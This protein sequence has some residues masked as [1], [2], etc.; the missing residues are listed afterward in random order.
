MKRTR[1][2][3]MIALLL[4]TV[5][6]VSLMVLPVCAAD[7][8]VT[9]VLTEAK[10]GVVQIYGLGYDRYNRLEA[11]WVGSGFCVS[12][13]ED[14]NAVFVTN[15]HVATGDGNY[16]EDHV[17]LWIL[18]ENCSIRDLDYQPDPSRSIECKIITTTFGSPDFAIIE[19]TKPT[20]DYKA[21]P[22]LSSKEVEI[23]DTVYALGYPANVGAVN[24]S[25][26][27]I[28]DITVTNGIVS[29]RMQD[30]FDATWVLMHT[31]LISGGN[32]GGPL[33]TEQGAVVGVNTYTFADN[34]YFAIY[35]D[36]IMDALD[37]EGIPYQVY[38]ETP[39]NPVLKIMI[40]AAI[41]L[42][43]LAG[44]VI[45]VVII[46]KGKKPAAD[47]VPEDSRH[48][49]PV[50]AP[51][52]RLKM[53][54]GR[55]ILVN[56]PVMTIGRDPGCDICVAREND[57]ISRY[58]CKLEIIQ[59]RLVVSDTASRNGTFI[60]GK[61]IPAGTRVALKIGSSF[62]MGKNDYVITVI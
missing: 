48:Q 42:A 50:P 11:T 57:N 31:A 10:Q 37:M 51:V 1:I 34:R 22:L 47:P 61:Q 55:I 20:D 4:A 16:D 58:H 9:D 28:E 43:A 59:G 27:G 7:G 5:C 2:L 3:S 21:L 49:D 45:V 52:F 29:Q 14:E 38:G 56:K 19:T 17:Q 35:T 54:D 23:G 8:S 12:N 53:P 46:L 26:S 40:I 18:Q 41:V 25:N 13:P 36:Y 62:A 24:T 33:I 30:S 44:V 15:W 39:G 60:H 6:I 32:S